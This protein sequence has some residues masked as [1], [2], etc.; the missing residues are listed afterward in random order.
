MRTAQYADV[1]QNKED[2]LLAF[3]RETDAPPPFS[4]ASHRRSD[5][6]ITIEFTPQ[7]INIPEP[8]AFLIASTVCLVHTP[9]ISKLY[10]L[11]NGEWQAYAIEPL[12][13]KII[14]HLFRWSAWPAN[15]RGRKVS[16]MRN[17]CGAKS[18]R[19]A[20]STIS[21]RVKR[22]EEFCEKHNI[23]PLIVQGE[24]KRWYFNKF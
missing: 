20:D 5:H 12:M 11:K 10:L 17:L 15:R 18:T 1:E 3:V 7:K 19:S 6:P 2:Q 24:G 13:A 9:L 21:S 16:E 14:E 23:P 4:A 22:I 8:E